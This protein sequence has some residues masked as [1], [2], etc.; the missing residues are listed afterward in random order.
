MQ[1]STETDITCK[2]SEVQVQS[3]YPGASGAI[4]RWKCKTQA[5][6]WFRYFHFLFCRSGPASVN[7]GTIFPHWQLSVVQTYLDMDPE[8][9][10]RTCGRWWDLTRCENFLGVKHEVTFKKK[11]KKGFKIDLIRMREAGLEVNK[12]GLGATLRWSSVRRNG[13]LFNL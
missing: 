10:T 6:L 13:F 2:L 1:V 7:A 12:C 5:V 3:G 4:S 9:A 11:K 8:E